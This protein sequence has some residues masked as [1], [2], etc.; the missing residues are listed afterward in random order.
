M[1]TF[2][3]YVA[4]DI[5]HKYGTD[6]SRIAVV[7]P[8][9]RAALFLN[10]HLARMA[11]KP[12][13]SPAY[14]TISDLFRQHSVLTV[15]DSIKLICDIHK[16]F[17]EETGIEESLDHFY[18]WGQLLLADF[19]DVDKNMADADK[20]FANLRDIHELD[21][22]SYLTDEQKNILRQFFSNFS[23]YQNSVLKE[24]FLKLWSRFGDIYKNFKHCLR[25]QQIAYEGMLYR[26]VATD[27]TAVFGHDMYVFVGFNVVQKVEQQIFSRLKKQ[28]KARFYWDFDHYYMPHRNNESL[29]A[30]EAGHYISQYLECFPNELDVTNAAIYD[31]FRQGTKKEITFISASTENIQARYIASWLKE[32]D[33]YKAG[34]KTAI[35]LCDESLLQSVIHCIP[36]EVDKI[37]ITTGFPLA[38]SPIS[39][40]LSQ[41][42]SLQTSGWSA[43][44]ERFRYKFVS[45][46]LCHP[47]SQYISP[48]YAELLS[49][50]REEGR[51]FI[52][53]KRLYVD[54]GLKMLFTPAKGNA[55]L[56]QWL[57]DI[58]RLVASNSN[59]NDPLF[60]E[61]VFRMYTLV[62]R[63]NCLVKS[64]DLCVDVITLQKLIAQIIGTT[65]IPFHGEPA[66]GVQ[67]MGVL[68]TRNLDFDHILLLS[69]NEGNMPKGVND[70]SFIPYSIRKAYG[71]TTID[72]KVAIYAYYFNRLLQRA[73]DVSI[74]YNDSTEDGHTGEMSRFML[75]LMVESGLNINRVSLQAGHNR[76]FNE[77][78]EIAK[79]SRI[80]EQMN[81]ISYLSPT[82]INRYIRCPLQ[83][84][85][86]NVAGIT[87]PENISEDSIDNRVF[88]NIFHAASEKV[89]RQMLGAGQRLT[90]EV[91]SLM[92]KDR[93]SIERIVDETINEIVFSLGKD[94]KERPQYNGLQIINREVIIRY[95]VRL[96]E[97]DRTLAPFSVLMLEGKVLAGLDYCVNGM[98]RA[99]QIGGRIDRMDQITDAETHEE[100]IRIVDYKTGGTLFKS[101][102][103]S[104]DDIFQTPPEPQKHA[105]YYLQTML[106]S[107]IVRA[108]SRQN[109]KNLPVSPALLFI[110]HTKEYG[111]DP[112][113]KIG[114]DKI[115]DIKDYADEFQKRI[116]DVVSSIFDP[117]KPFR[118]TTDSTVCNLC[119][120][121]A[122][123]G[124]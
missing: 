26:D 50:L 6:L 41:L 91:I 33:R 107:M 85:Y 7:F 13:W 120:Y 40:Y 48:H 70:S 37:N 32:N 68:E 22:I 81:N 76:L 8:N 21:D 117:A 14:I 78:R 71:L 103:N 80:M 51:F 109:P 75:Q 28:G 17:T 82:A 54:E 100:R 122:M 92:L 93:K 96:L 60:T 58:L 115:A 94:S 79:D 84:Y 49:K 9:K 16:S 36:P 5:L 111:Y 34:R 124:I 73:C 52:P 23:E 27:E 25:E 110:Q 61:S 42:I 62:N 123:C 64:G 118:P 15:G 95:I 63:I 57:L 114:K 112:V 119:P 99:V 2:L 89:Y 98:R 116:S 12:V 43:S 66:E 39:S 46:I 38:N 101:R 108:D 97:I 55:S 59:N 24:R 20:V 18:G 67:I 83:F 31:N 104:I 72:N 53:Q 105:D 86:N 45:Q 4:E 30:N 29:A 3:E 74:A 19:D 87:E 106:Y 65:T 90:C 11:E 35:V 56:L 113:I 69:C 44:S 47:Y 1:K 88:G 77:P 121:A 10:E 102:I